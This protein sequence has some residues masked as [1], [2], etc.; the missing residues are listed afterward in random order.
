[1]IKA[2]IFLKSCVRALVAGAKE[3]PVVGIPIRM[4]EAFYATWVMELQQAQDSLPEVERVEQ[5]EE[6]GRCTPTQVR[7]IVEECV[8]NVT[9]GA[10]LPAEQRQAVIEVASLIPGQVRQQTQ[11]TLGH[12][13]RYGTASFVALPVGTRAV[14]EERA[15]FYRGLLPNRRLQFHDH[16]IIEH[17]DLQLQSKSSWELLKLIGLGGFGEVWLGMHSVTG[18]QRA[19]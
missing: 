18:E 2:Q 3:L 11:C 7:A 4:A 5:L 9:G 1:M 14:P 19:F 8:A 10:N 15:D 13:R 6:V 17:E 12:A 16:A